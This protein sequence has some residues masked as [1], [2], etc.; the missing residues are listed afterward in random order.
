MNKLRVP[1]SSKFLLLN[2]NL[3]K[4]MRYKFREFNDN[5][6]FAYTEYTKNNKIHYKFSS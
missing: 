6:K 4:P 1:I 5:L 2:R 3:A